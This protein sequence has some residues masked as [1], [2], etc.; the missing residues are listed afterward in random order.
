MTTEPA[1]PRVARPPSDFL[2]DKVRSLQPSG[3]RRFFDMLAE[4]KDVISLTIGEPDFT[5]PEPITRAA[6]AS[7]E[8]GQT[9]YP[10]NGGMVELR[11]AIVEDLA[12]RYG[13]EYD[14]RSELIITVGASEALDATLRAICDPGDE[15]IYHEPSFV[16]Y[17]PCITLA[18]GIPVAISTGDET[19]FQL[20]AAQI[21]AAITPR[22]K[23]LFL[24]YPNNPTGAVLDLDELEK[25][26]AV[27]ERH[28]LL[29]ISDEIYERLVYGG[30][31]HVPFS[32]LPGMS[33]RTVLIGGFSKSY[34]MTGWRIGWVA[35]PADLMVGIAK[36]HQYGIMCAPT[37]AQFAALEALR[38]GE[39]FVLE[40][41]AEYDRRRQLMTRRLNEIGLR[42]FEPRGAF[43]CFPNIR[44]TGMDDETF[45]QELLREER[46]A[47]VPGTAFGPSGAGHVRMCYATAYEDLV[48]ALDRMERFVKRRSA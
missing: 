25:I 8:A 36:V 28:D 4:M 45:A 38:I 16:A 26:A 34:A 48:E 40:M 37:V 9:H 32:A 33:E 7:L 24:G 44:R 14:P 10:A 39:P 35:A 2:S 11:V 20:T 31:E 5:T 1:S 42:C 6:I 22:T 21:E 46:V 27:V 15:V 47:V 29:V 12:A 17:A 23:A 30:H 13:I 18:G 3:I 43:Y 19:D 41:R